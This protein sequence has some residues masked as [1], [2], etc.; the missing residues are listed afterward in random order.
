MT[1]VSRPDRLAEAAARRS[2][3]GCPE[4]RRVRTSSARPRSAPTGQGS[5]GGTSWR[6][7]RMTRSSVS[8]RGA[9][10]SGSSLCL[11]LQPARPLPQRNRPATVASQNDCTTA[12]AAG[13]ALPPSLAVLAA[14]R[15]EPWAGS[16]RP[17]GTCIGE[18]RWCLMG[19][20]FK[21]TLLQV[22]LTRGRREGAEGTGPRVSH[23][24][25]PRP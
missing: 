17:R 22:R 3:P 6:E 23:F 4:S 10:H 21:P 18:W 2:W 9:S 5:P 19:Y 25:K 8:P 15:G 12:A 14:W 11:F 24:S 1:G 16:H 7:E 13:L 20:P